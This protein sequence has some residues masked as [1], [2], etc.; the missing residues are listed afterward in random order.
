MVLATANAVPA[1]ALAPVSST[2]ASLTGTTVIK[3]PP[4]VVDLV[5][6]T[7]QGNGSAKLDVASAHTVSHERVSA[8]S[9]KPVPKTTIRQKATPNTVSGPDEFDVLSTN[10]AFDRNTCNPQVMTSGEM[11]RLCTT[12]YI[13]QGFS[14]QYSASFEWQLTD[15]CG[16]V[17]VDRTINATVQ[18]SGP[19]TEFWDTSFPFPWNEPPQCE[20]TWMMS[21]TLS[22]AFPDGQTLTGTV[23]GSVTVAPDAPGTAL[24]A[25][26][27]I[28]GSPAH[29]SQADPVDSFTG[30][31]N[32]HM[33]SDLSMAGL[34]GGLQVQR[35]YSSN[36][37]RSSAF[38]P[39]W[40]F[41]YDATVTV[42]P[43]IGNVTYHDPSGSQQVFTPDGSGGYVPPAGVV[44]SLAPVSGGGFLLRDWDSNQKIFDSGGKL[45]QMLDHNLQ[46]PSFTYSGS[47]LATATDSG[48][49][50][51]FTW[52]ATGTRIIGVSGS[53]SRS[54][55][56]GYDGSL[57]LT[58]ETDP[59]GKTSIYGYDGAGRLNSIKDPNNNYPV[60]LIYDGTSGRVV[61]QQDANGAT[62]T[63]AWDSSTQTATTTDPR[64]LAS[65]DVYLNGFLI[66]QID[67][68]GDTTRYSWND[69]G[70]LLRVSDPRGKTTT[71][72][73]DA[74]GNTVAKI[75]P[76]LSTTGALDPTELYSYDANNNLISMTDFNGTVTQYGYDSHNNQT[77]V[78]RPD[79]VSGSG[80]VVAIQNGYNPDGTLATT[81]DSNGA[82]TTYGYNSSGDLTSVTTAAGRKTTFG[83]DAA[84]R[85]TSAVSPRGNVT[86]A[87]SATYT[88]TYTLNADG[89]ITQTVAPM[90]ITTSAIYDDA[91]RT[92]STTDARGKTTT[93]GYDADGHVISVQGPDVT[94]APERFSYDAD[95][96]VLTNTSSA[97]IVTTYTYNSIN[98]RATAQTTGAGQYS[99]TYDAAGN[100][101]TQTNPSG[102]VTTFSRGD[103]GELTSV[104]ATD[105]TNTVATTYGYDRNGNRTTMSDAHSTTTYAYNALNEVKSATRGTLAWSYG[106]D[107]AGRT[108]SRTTPGS[109]AQVLGYDPDG[110]LTG[111]TAGSTSLVSYAYNDTTGAT[112]ATLPGGVT[113]TTLIDAAGRPTKVTGAKGSTI[114]TQS[115]YVLDPNGDPTSITDASGATDTYTYDTSSRLSQVCYSTTTCTG[116]TN[117]ISWTYNGDGNRLTE[118][119]PAGAT[120]YTY[121]TTGRLASKSGASGA[122][123][124]TYDADGNMIGDGTNTYA[125][126]PAGNLT[127]A[128][129]SKKTTYTYDG[130]SRRLSITNG[131]TVVDPI[132]DPTTGQLDAEQSGSGSTLRTYTYGTSLVGLTA[133]SSSYSY[134]T[135]AQG[136][137][138]AVTDSTGTAQWTY[139][140]EPYGTARSA[141]A[142]RKAP[143]NPRQYLS[144]LADGSSYDLTARQYVPSIG[145]FLS[146]DPAAN[147][148]LGYQYGNA[149]PMTTIDP[150][151]MS[152]SS[153]LAV[154]GSITSGAA[155]TSGT[156]KA[157][158]TTA[159]WCS[160]LPAGAAP[161]SGVAG[162]VSGA[163]GSNT[164]SCSSTKGGCPA[165]VVYAS[166]SGSTGGGGLHNVT[167]GTAGPDWNG[168]LGG[169]VSVAAALVLGVLVGASI[170]AVCAA[171]ALVGC[172]IAGVVG[173]AIIGGVAGGTG[174]LVSGG[175]TRAAMGD[176]MI[177]GAIGGVAGGSNWGP[178][179]KLLFGENP[180]G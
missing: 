144:A 11:G 55:S 151:G 137:V 16:T 60:R 24:N 98:K 174:A 29:A 159:T 67:P 143:T 120:N 99:Y 59:R 142:G 22:Q 73:Y 77:T 140:F 177:T 5:G 173:G 4:P 157:N 25:G 148:G 95:G 162:A 179:D 84:G 129:A 32:D 103:S 91:G 28:G 79:V 112:V 56:Y 19:V 116:S 18:Y 168:I 163:P 78:T 119:R 107:N 45:T 69:N 7:A 136:S 123:T 49:T 14:A 46:G 96:N 97:G 110:R 50:L 80:T 171:T 149:N 167:A 71:F 138:R 20:G 72:R 127:S 92:T 1:G 113:Q 169:A 161:L 76:D 172:I 135:D 85:Q 175:D 88:T 122:A 93:T 166:L 75:A 180:F 152:G 87:N 89:Q 146:P 170:A 108:V 13:N 48:R 81:T 62:T 42:D 2:A 109:A 104:S 66:Q 128:G 47:L 90:G 165:N 36:S 61:Q 27:T 160:Q 94:I 65:Q 31:F 115:T 23:I 63:F 12:I 101:A 111:V 40:T 121:N 44:S 26:Q 141:V 8:P 68:A 176:G 17:V 102:H 10:A 53:D 124:Y 164:S 33:G 9:A 105:G 83:Y 134:L 139:S 57:N 150:F 147:P 153:W 70:Q 51:T 125:W 52:D 156:V 41:D 86:G 6:G 100:I 126:D 3:T 145:Q 34:G 38:G 106:Y 130:D 132:W 154:S 155:T 82:V 178:F 35:S 15:A 58:S 39:G 158:C 21:S 133:G 118:T 131:S 74:Q 64:G 54:I 37:S 114:L 117:Y 43:G 30:A